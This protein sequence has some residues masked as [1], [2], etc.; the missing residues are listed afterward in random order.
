MAIGTI[1]MILNIL[2]IGIKLVKI[3]FVFS[4]ILLFSLHDLNAGEKEVN[5]AWCNKNNG[6]IEYRT[7]YGTYV[8]C[9]LE[10][11]AVES[12]YDYK[13]K[14]GVGQSL[15]YAESTGKKAAILFIRRVKTKKDFMSELKKTI[16]YHELPITIFEVY[17]R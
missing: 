14:E 6:Q 5:A 12:E 13:W 2:V 8:D 15:H 4:S 1:P 17:E 9:L 10:E 16:E 3:F 11:Y 7:R